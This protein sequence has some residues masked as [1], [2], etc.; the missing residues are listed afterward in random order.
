MEQVKGVSTVRLL[1]S[2]AT[3]EAQRL[4]FQFQGH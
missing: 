1:R 3:C 4:E 2:S